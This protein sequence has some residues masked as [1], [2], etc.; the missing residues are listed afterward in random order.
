MTPDAAPPIDSA[1]LE[2][3]AL[4]YLERY[5]SSAGHLRLVLRRRAGRC[6]GGDRAALA[7]A[8]D[9]IEA[10]IERYRAVGLIDDAAYAAGRAQRRLARGESLRRIAAGLAAKGVGTED[11]AAAL[12]GLKDDTA[13]PDLAAA[14]AFARR[15]RLGPFRHRPADPV[16][17]RRELAAFAR[18]GFARRIAEGVL[19]CPDE[20]ALAAL[21]A[22]AA[23]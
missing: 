14:C 21:L 20:T 10:L 12:Q 17:R 18:G 4:F 22:D 15:R 7:A 1:L 8:G 19:A 9:L 5:A 13:D 16:E 2:K 6:A 11:V 3:W 23:R